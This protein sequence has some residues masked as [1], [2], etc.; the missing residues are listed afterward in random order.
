MVDPMDVCE[1]GG[2]IVYLKPPTAPAAEREF[3]KQFKNPTGLLADGSTFDTKHA[4]RAANYGI[5]NLLFGGK[6]EQAVT[7]SKVSIKAVK[8]NPHPKPCGS[9][10]RVAVAT[11]T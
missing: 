6:G 9:D 8:Y 5:I 11:P 2:G 4:A 10:R 7:I 3:N 1:G